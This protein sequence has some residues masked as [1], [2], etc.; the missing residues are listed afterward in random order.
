MLRKL[1]GFCALQ[2]DEEVEEED[3]EE[4]EKI[5]EKLQRNP[6]SYLCRQSRRRASEG[7]KKRITRKSRAARTKMAARALFAFDAIKSLHQLLRQWT[8]AD[9]ERGRGDETR[10]DE[11]IR[12]GDVARR[13]RR[14]E[15]RQFH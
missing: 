3:A 12:V 8:T 2:T 1:F 4:D 5:N 6:H 11:T 7:M 10:R 14:N 15:T 9:A 13:M